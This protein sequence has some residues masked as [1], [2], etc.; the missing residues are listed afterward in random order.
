MKN[1]YFW[2]GEPVKITFGNCVVKS[3]PGFPLWWY[4][5]ECRTYGEF[6]SIY[7]T[8]IFPAILV[9]SSTDFVI[10]NHFGIGINKLTKGGW[11][12]QT[13]FSL[14]IDCFKSRP[15]FKIL[16]FDE[17]SYANHEAARE[18]WQKEN[19]PAEYKKMK[20]LRGSFKINS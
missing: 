14:P 3:K 16:E 4:N 13:H 17:E 8:A 11:P 18:K 5:F 1:K 15:K 7:D 9:H 10:S 20:A 19:Y 2:Q 6:G 12:N